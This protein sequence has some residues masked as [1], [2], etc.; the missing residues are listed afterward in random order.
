MISY[1]KT[2]ALKGSNVS[3]EV[4]I[5]DWADRYSIARLNKALDAVA[6]RPVR[7]M[8]RY[9][10]HNPLMCNAS[11][12]FDVTLKSEYRL[13]YLLKQ[14]IQQKDRIQRPEVIERHRLVVQL[15]R[16]LKIRRSVART[17]FAETPIAD[18]VYLLEFGTIP[19]KGQLS[20]ELT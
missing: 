5:D 4:L 9:C 19:A 12:A 15:S 17:Q 7:R 8:A 11:T 6:K 20:L 3:D 16:K 1:L 18:L 13:I 2:T 10:A 14:A